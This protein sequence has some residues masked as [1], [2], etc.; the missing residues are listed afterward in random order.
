MN[1]N[2]LSDFVWFMQGDSLTLA[3]VEGKEVKIN[4]YQTI[5][6]RY[7]EAMIIE[8]EFD[9]MK[10]NVIT[11]STRVMRAITSCPSFP[12]MATFVKSD[13]RWQIK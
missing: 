1:E 6:T 10:R 4:R 12:V 8:V 13:N 2:R 7:G 9:G 5:N 3:D 11:S